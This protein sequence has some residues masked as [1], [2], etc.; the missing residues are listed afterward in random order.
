MWLKPLEE[1]EPT[2]PSRT[3]TLFEL[4]KEVEPALTALSRNEH[5]IAQEIQKQENNKVSV[6]KLPSRFKP[7]DWVSRTFRVSSSSLC[8]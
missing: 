3:R 5:R 2:L 4:E 6:A 1:T 8:G 7:V